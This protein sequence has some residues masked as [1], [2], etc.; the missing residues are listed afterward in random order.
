MTINWVDLAKTPDG[1]IPAK[2]DALLRG[3]DKNNLVSILKS[4]EVTP[5]ENLRASIYLHLLIKSK[6]KL[7]RL[8]I[9]PNLGNNKICPFSTALTSKNLLNELAKVL[10]FYLEMPIYFHAKGL[11]KPESKNKY[12]DYFK[13]NFFNGDFKNKRD[14][15]LNSNIIAAHALNILTDHFLGNIEEACRRI[16]TDIGNIKNLFIDVYPALEFQELKEIKSTGSDFHKGGKQVLILSFKIKTDPT[17]DF[18]LIYKPGDLEIDCLLVGMSSAIKPIYKT[19]MEKSLVE[20]INDKSDELKLPFVKLR[21][22]RIL[23]INPTSQYSD[24]DLKRRINESYG[25]IEYL[26]YDK[27][28]NTKNEKIDDIAGNFYLSMG[29]WAAIASIFSFTDVHIENIIVNRHDPVLIDFEISLINLVDD[30]CKDTKMIM[31]TAGGISSFETNPKHLRLVIDKSGIDAK[32]EGKPVMGKNRLYKS[33]K[34]GSEIIKI[35]WNDLITGVNI[36]MTVLRDV[37]CEQPLPNKFSAWWGRL[38]NVLVRYPPY[39]TVEFK[40]N[41][42]NLY[43]FGDQQHKDL[44][45]TVRELID[46]NYSEK[47]DLNEEPPKYV[48]WNANIVVNDLINLD[49]P[50]FYNRI[51]TSDLL[52]SRGNKINRPSSETFFKVPPISRIEDERIKALCSN[53]GFDQLKAKFLEQLGRELVKH[54]T[55]NKII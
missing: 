1:E 25:Y 39:S 42:Y 7:L 41:I 45:P 2:I 55:G 4:L 8:A 47:R 43:R 14:A 29:Q 31:D 52:D 49:V 21:T 18:R 51:G 12:E 19:F 30:I 23:P 16:I 24:D 54:Q 17:K 34:S 27:P 40:N 15:F 22:L 3:I 11:I 9:D 46:R 36:G 44:D 50:V 37:L 32:N 5:P 48:I 6:I 13:D 53:S 10:D 35:D 28:I 26:E 20:I 38:R 33:T